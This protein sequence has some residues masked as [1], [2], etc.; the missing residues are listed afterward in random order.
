MTEPQQ[1]PAGETKKLLENPVVGSLV[2]PIAIVLVGALI[3]FGVTK[4]LSTDRSYRDLVRE[5]HSKT[6]GNRWIAAY[7]LSKQI[8]AKKIP[9]EEVPWLV[10]NLSEVYDQAVDPRTRN[11]I[12]VALGTIKS[13]QA[14]PVILKGLNDKDSNVQ[15]HSM[16][17]IGNMPST[18]P[19]E[20]DPILEK[21]R[22]TKDDGLRQAIILGAATHKVGKARPDLV[23][24]LDSDVQSIRYAAA[25]GLINFK[26]EKAAPVLEEILFLIPPTTKPEPGQLGA[27]ETVGLQ[28][29]IVSALQK[30]EWK[31]LNVA[32]GKLIETSGNK[33]LVVKAQE[34]LNLLKN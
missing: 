28:L 22:N 7:E 13:E 27:N 29:N 23:G 18:F 6:F 15:F 1:P 31:I 17:A 5:L 3:I 26:E 4:M 2:V 25:L 9:T 10:A 24:Y 32:L 33:K 20:W 16:V 21:M 34:A 12:I 8:S 19:I 30:N 14:L 11:F